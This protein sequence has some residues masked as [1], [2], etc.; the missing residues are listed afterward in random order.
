[1]IRPKKEGEYV[2]LDKRKITQQEW[3]TYNQRWYQWYE[4]YKDRWTSMEASMS[5][6]TPPNAMYAH[7]H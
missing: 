4:R 6:P 5:Q 2:T 3:D 1:M 7:T